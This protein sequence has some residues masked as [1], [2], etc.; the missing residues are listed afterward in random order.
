MTQGA[1][2]RAS[3][4]RPP[5]RT[6]TLIKGARILDPV[7]GYADQT[8][9]LLREGRIE[10][11]GKGLSAPAEAVLVEADGAI[12]TPGLVDPHTHLGVFA[13][14]YAPSQGPSSDVNEAGGPVAADARAEDSV[15]TQ[16]PQFA[17]ALA[18]GVTTLCVLPGS[19]ALIGGLT[20]TLKNVPG[21]IVDEMLFPGAPKALKL[22]CGDNPKRHLVER[23]AGPSSRMGLAAAFRQAWMQARAHADARARAAANGG[24]P[25]APD[26]KLEV[27]SAAMRREIGVRVHAYRADDMATMRALAREFGF[28]IIAFEHALEGYKVPDLLTESDIAA[29]V[30]S[31]WW[32]FKTEAYDG[33][34]ENAAFLEAAGVLVALHS[35]IAS[36]GRRLGVEAGKAMAAG[37]RAGIDITPAQAIAWVTLNPA[38]VLGLEAQIGS[39]EAGKNADLAIWRGDPFSIHGRAE[40]VFIDGALVLDRKARVTPLSDFELGQEGRAPGA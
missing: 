10:A 38:R 36:T 15:D 37:R 11:L 27:L 7:V 31:D 26:P 2:G 33:V 29:V 39:V 20:A 32:G 5:P 35:D 14:P 24:E 17:R 8:D 1:R 34:R 21:R 9:V 30:W 16:D 13:A 19:L 3:A 18:G 25:P 4:Y 23:G 6:D 12:V 40:K 28:R 22:A